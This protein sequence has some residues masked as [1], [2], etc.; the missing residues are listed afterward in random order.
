MRNV[1]IATVIVVS[2]WGRLRGD[3]ISR[4][5]AKLDIQ[6]EVAWNDAA[7]LPAPAVD[8]A[9]YLRRVY[10]DIAGTLPPPAKIREFLLDPSSDKRT[11]VVDQLLASPEYAT[12]W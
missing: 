8:E 2:A 1:V 4:T 3:D 7:I 12:R 5:V 10:L 11:R 9:G 6:F